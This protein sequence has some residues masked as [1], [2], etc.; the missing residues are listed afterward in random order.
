MLTEKE[1]EIVRALL[2]EE[3]VHVVNHK[4]CNDGSFNDLLASY[5][6][7]LSDILTKIRS[8]ESTLFFSEVAG[9][10]G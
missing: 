6:S 10:I 4:E 3:I 5:R 8:N 1:K 9:I 7:T 2:E